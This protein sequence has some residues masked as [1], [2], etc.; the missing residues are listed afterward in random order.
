MTYSGNSQVPAITTNQG[1][2][3]GRWVKGHVLNRVRFPSGG[4]YRATHYRGIIR[5]EATKWAFIRP[6][7]K[8]KEDSIDRSHSR[9]RC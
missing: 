7:L 9:I 8:Y 5:S 6:I 3:K 2:E 1:L 4:R